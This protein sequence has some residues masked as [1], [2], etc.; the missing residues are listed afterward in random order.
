MRK[1]WGRSPTRSPLRRSPLLTQGWCMDLE[2]ELRGPFQV[3]SEHIEP[4]S[5][6]P[7]AQPPAPAPPPPAPATPVFVGRGWDLRTDTGAGIG[8]STPHAPAPFTPAWSPGSR[9]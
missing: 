7:A 1:D 8:H 9:V 4:H 5:L 3:Q 6:V 2:Q